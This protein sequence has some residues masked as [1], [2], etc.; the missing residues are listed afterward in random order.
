MVLYFWK[1]FLFI[2]WCKFLF[3][4]RLNF[5]S[6][7][8]RI[9]TVELYWI[10]FYMSSTAIAFYRVMVYYCGGVT[11]GNLKVTYW[12]NVKVTKSIDSII[13][14]R[15]APLFTCA[16]E[17]GRVYYLYIF[18]FDLISNQILISIW[19][20]ACIRGLNHEKFATESE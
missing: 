10:N 19:K 4:R 2:Q 20:W 8:V 7:N 11:F 13:F 15:N 17:E 16:L 14:K 1:S 5:G 6:N 12:P 9:C 18:Q 3:F